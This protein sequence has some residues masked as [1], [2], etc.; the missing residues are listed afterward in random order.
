MN[1]ALFQGKIIDTFADGTAWPPVGMISILQPLVTLGC[2]S[3]R[4]NATSV[5]TVDAQMDVDG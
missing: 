4:S 2:R 1:Q 3:A 5:A